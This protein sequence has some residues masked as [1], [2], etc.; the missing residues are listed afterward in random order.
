M[1]EVEALADA[2]EFD[3]EVAADQLQRDFLAGVADGEVDF[4]EA[5][6]ADAALD[7]VAGQRTVAAGVDESPRHGGRRTGPLLA[8][9][10]LRYL[11]G[12]FQGITCARFGAVYCTLCNASNASWRRSQARAI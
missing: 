7:R 8:I 1:L 4:A 11:A 10:L 6:L 9:P 3:V 5:A 2:A 12:W